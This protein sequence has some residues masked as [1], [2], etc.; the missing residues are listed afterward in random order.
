M[1]LEDIIDTAHLRSLLTR[2]AEGKE[3]PQILKGMTKLNKKQGTSDIT[4]L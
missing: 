1:I 4:Y 2:A 3:P